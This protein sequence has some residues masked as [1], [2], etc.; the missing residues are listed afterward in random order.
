MKTKP[1]CRRMKD[2]WAPALEYENGGVV[3]AAFRCETMSEALREAS[4]MIGWKKVSPDAFTS[5]HPAPTQLTDL[6][7]E[8]NQRNP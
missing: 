6:T 1:S 4:A 3:I 7:E 8:T 2:G 5:I